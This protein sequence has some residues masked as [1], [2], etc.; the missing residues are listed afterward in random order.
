MF[1][2]L[3]GG[4]W[5]PSKTTGMATYVADL[6]IRW[7]NSGFSIE[8]RSTCRADGELVLVHLNNIGVQS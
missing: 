8:L 7:L 6:A 1:V 4:L 3:D 5:S 2:L